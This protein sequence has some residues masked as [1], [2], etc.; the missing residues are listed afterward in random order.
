MTVLSLTES[1]RLAR[2]T[3]HA[4]SVGG[5]AWT[6]QKR[7]HHQSSTSSSSLPFIAGRGRHVT[8]A[9]AALSIGGGTFFIVVGFLILQHFA[10]ESL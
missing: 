1:K 7:L 6:K 3:F 2:L 9:L 4:H 5:D 8:R 10:N